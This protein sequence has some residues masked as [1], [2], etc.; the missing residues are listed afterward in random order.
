MIVGKNE[1]PQDVIDKHHQEVAEKLGVSF[2]S[3]KKFDSILHRVVSES[4]KNDTDSSKAILAMYAEVSGDADLMKMTCLV[5][6]NCT[7][8]GFIQRINLDAMKSSVM[9]NILSE[10]LGDSDE[11]VKQ[12]AG[13][14]IP[15]DVH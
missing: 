12:G 1:I 7:I 15:G 4:L 6:V 8:E 3:L 9:G 2:E 11:E 14:N 13:D 5:A 10:I